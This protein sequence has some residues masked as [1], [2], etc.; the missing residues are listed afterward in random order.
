MGQNPFIDLIK[1]LYKHFRLLSIVF[2]VVLVLTYLGLKFF[3]TPKY[4]SEAVIYP[5]NIH[6]L[7]SEDETEHAIQ[8]LASEDI[9]WKMIDSFG[10][11]EHYGFNP[12]KVNYENLS[13]K[14]S[15]H[16]KVERTT[17][18][19]ISITVLDIEAQ[20]AA[21][22][23]NAIVELMN[24]KILHMR[25][26]KYKEWATTAKKKMNDKQA[27][28]NLIEA[29]VNKIKTE[30]GIVN[31]EEQSADV[32][33]QV[34]KVLSRIEEAD[35]KIKVYGKYTSAK[36]RDSVI[37]YNIIKESITPKY[38][39]LDTLFNNMLRVG[40]RIKSLEKTIEFELETLAEYKAEYEEHQ[41][42]AERKISYSYVISKAGAADKPFYPK[43]VMSAAVAA[44]SV[45]LLLILYLIIAEQFNRIKDQL[46]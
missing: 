32:S 2:V 16:V 27:Q 22:M 41:Q 43:K 15:K 20:K 46:N 6:T 44:I 38:R 25:R 33:Q 10:L 42:S 24:R 21:D 3:V 9:K 8:I 19:S 36:Y 31:L 14:Y 34:N 13:R 12:E 18:S 11:I 35:A 29:N 40:D 28:I 7:S 17:Y 39:K 5:A 23:A 26:E 30:N 1:F 37:K 45:V 4:L